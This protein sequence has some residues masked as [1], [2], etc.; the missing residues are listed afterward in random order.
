MLVLILYCDEALASPIQ[1]SFPAFFIN[2]ARTSITSGFVVSEDE[3]FTKFGLRRMCFFPLVTE[4]RPPMRSMALVTAYS[5]PFASLHFS[6][7]FTILTT[8]FWPEKYIGLGVY[9][10]GIIS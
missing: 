3:E 2:T 6:L 8:G 10:G 5:I 9:K 7:I 4:F 1:T